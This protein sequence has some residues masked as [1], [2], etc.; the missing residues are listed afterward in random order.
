MGGRWRGRPAWGVAVILVLVVPVLA[1]GCTIRARP[2]APSTAPPAGA[3]TTTVATVHG[4]TVARRAFL[5]DF[6]SPGS[7]VRAAPDGPLP[8]AFRRCV[9][10]TRSPSSPPTR[11]CWRR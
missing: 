9:S 6:G 7:P 11:R 8:V 5:V 1:A 2:E 4:T 3:P 10:T